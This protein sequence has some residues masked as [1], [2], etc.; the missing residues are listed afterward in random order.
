MT[1]QTP[2]QNGVVI[3]DVPGPAGGIQIRV[4]GKT[5][6]T[7]AEGY[8]ALDT[9]KASIKMVGPTILIDAN[10]ISFNGTA[11]TINK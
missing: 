1:F 6:I 7:V 8:I 11:L 5:M 9:G 4:H 10:L 2:S 3:N